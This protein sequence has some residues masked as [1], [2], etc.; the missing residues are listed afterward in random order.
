M[1]NTSFKILASLT[2]SLCL[3]SPSLAWEQH[4]L[5][6]SYIDS[7][8]PHYGGNKAPLALSSSHIQIIKPQT[9]GFSL[10]NSN[11]DGV[12][13]TSTQVSNNPAFTH[14]YL[15]SS[16]LI[17]GWGETQVPTLFHR[18]LSSSSWS[19]SNFAWP[20]AN[21]NIIDVSS[22]TAGDIVIL[23]TTP[24]NHKLVEGELFFIRGNQ[25]GWSNPIQL[26]APHSL[27]GDASLVVH[28]SS[29]IS[30]V[31]SERNHN[32]WHILSRNSYDTTTWSSTQTIVEYIAAPYFQEAAIQ[33]DADALNQS[34]IAL[35]Y[36][37]WYMQAH[38]QVWSK[39]FD[40]ISGQTTQPNDLLPDAGDMVY[41]PSLVTLANNTWA[42][43]WQQT[44]GIDSEIF[45]AQHQ[46]DGT[47]STSVNVSADPNHMDRDPHIA[48]GSSQTLNIAF[49]RRIQADIQE[50]YIFTE[51]DIHDS[52]L[53]S[54]GDGIPDSQELGFDL[55]HDGI[56]D[57]FSSRVAT[58]M[59]Q[60][61][62]YALVVQGSGELRQ[63]QAPS[64]KNAN[65]EQPTTYHVSSNLFSFQIH[66]LQQGETTPVHII[67]PGTLDKNTTWLKLNPN[68]Q[69]SDSVK[70]TVFHDDSGK[71]LIVYLT[72]GGAG[73]EDGMADG[74]IIDPAVLATQEISPA[75]ININETNITSAA[76]PC[77]APTGQNPWLLSM[78]SIFMIGI[79]IANKRNQEKVI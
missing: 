64:L 38:S 34:E 5:P 35:A 63:V 53:D 31:W 37:G 25:Q 62:R 24:S 78:F 4:T 57:A 69:W 65:I 14:M 61:G 77:L 46:A 8:T 47:W 73:D 74:I 1:F 36:T 72:D 40:T 33:L 39:A 32:S 75:N 44:I 42:V 3:V 15:A 9:D 22:S 26:S 45:M 66:A 27:V 68:A 29:L 52:S 21:W 55:N 13:W 58:W 71:G 23:A 16:D 7:N 6:S 56:D 70:N 43:A 76:Q 41:Q 51:G 67:T 79:T 11:N 10:W 28:D 54:D 60:H 49:T 18:T 30:A 48:Q 20:L 59:S 19:A 50:V 17:L 2:L 12:S